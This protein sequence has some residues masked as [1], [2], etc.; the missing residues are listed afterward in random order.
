MDAKDILKGTQEQALASWINYLNQVR[1]DQLMQDLR[2]QDRN[3]LEAL[4]QMDWAQ[5]NVD[6]TILSNRGADTG[7]H[8]FLAEILE[9]GINNARRSINGLSPNMEWINDNDA[10]DLVRDGIGIQQKFYQSDGLFSLNA[11]AKHLDHYPDFL[12]AGMK[13]QIP[14][15][16]YEKVL[17]LNSL[18]EKEAF[19]QLNATTDPTIGQWR[20]VHTFFKGSK[21]KVNDF[22]PSHIRYDQAQ[23][24]NVN[25]TVAEEKGNLHS[26]DKQNREAAYQKSK[27]SLS[28]GTKA[29]VVSASIEGL[30]TFCL[31]ISRKRKNKKISEFN[32]DDWIEISKKSGFG[33][34]KGG[35]RGSSMYILSNFTATPAFVANSVVTSSFGLAEQ[36]HLYRNGTLSELELIESSEILC[37]EAS[38]SA[39]SSLLGQVAIPVPILGAMIGNTVGN[40]L[41]QISKDYFTGKEQ[42]LINRFADEQSKLDLNLSKEYDQ[43]IHLL[44][45][46]MSAYL[47]ILNKAFSPDIRVAFKG[48]ILLAKSMGV[49]SDEILGDLES[50]D[51]YFKV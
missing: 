2:L 22:E 25:K 7:I 40:I 12:K 34:V 5:I 19:H 21:L 27:P 44:D 30:T 10:V 37:L 4:K 46:N 3:L 38:V 17:F 11:A 13:Y 48:S 41:F 42:E 20:K 33:F 29:T 45:K 23:K 26:I 28:Q 51:S 8:G 36:F 31:E 43:Y 50:I 18:S 39:L 6:K 47:N 15:D 32:T 1:L 49:E 24:A 16:Q 14:K 35:L 9:T